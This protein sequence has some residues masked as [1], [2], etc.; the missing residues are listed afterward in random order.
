[1]QFAVLPP[2]KPAGSRDAASSCFLSVCNLLF[3]FSSLLSCGEKG[4]S[5][6]SGCEKFRCFISWLVYLFYKRQLENEWAFRAFD[7]SGNESQKAV[8]SD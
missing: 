6:E 1:M 3:F 5:F 2:S 7:V 4:A 8:A